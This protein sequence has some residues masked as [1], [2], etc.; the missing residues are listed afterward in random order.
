MYRAGTSIFDCPNVLLV[1]V[2]RLLGM[3]HCAMQSFVLVQ[4]F[5]KILEKG[6]ILAFVSWDKEPAHGVCIHAVSKNEKGLLQVEVYDPLYGD[7]IVT[8]DDV[9]YKF[10]P[11]QTYRKVVYVVS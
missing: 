2:N 9:R 8:S 5:K 6:M 11:G 7:K 1:C 10:K 3:R 4:D